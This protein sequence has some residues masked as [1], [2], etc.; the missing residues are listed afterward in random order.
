MADTTSYKYLNK[1]L[2]IIVK[3]CGSIY[4]EMINEALLKVKE[5][6]KY[7]SIYNRWFSENS[8]GPE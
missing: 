5:N 2:G 8:E 6:G 1:Q 4:R 3:G 7:N